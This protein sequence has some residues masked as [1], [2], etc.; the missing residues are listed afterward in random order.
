MSH[1]GS[2]VSALL[3]GRLPQAEEERCW[4]HVHECHAC[5]DLVERE[6]WVK[7]RLAQLSTG[8]ACAPDALK[9]SLRGH[10]PQLVPPA[11]PTASRHRNRGLVAIG[12]GAVGACVV[13]VLALG[14]GA[15]PRM[16]PRPPVTDLSRPTV[17]SSPATSDAARARRSGQQSSTRSPLAERLVAVGEKMAP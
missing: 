15:T 9:N 16:D 5:R 12:G 13:G 11:F 1:L 6:G 3:D 4:A 17:P 7:T 10:T 2:K 8:P 14:L